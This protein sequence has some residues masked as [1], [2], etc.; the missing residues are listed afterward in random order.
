MSFTYLKKALFVSAFFY[1]GCISVHSATCVIELTKDG[2]RLS[3]GVVKQ[4]IDG[5]T[6]HL[7]DGRK[8]RLLNIDTPEIN[9]DNPSLSEPL[10]I[11]ARQ[12]LNS[13]IKAGQK[14]W[15]ESDHRTH[16]RFKRQLAHVYDGQKRHLGAALIKK[17]LAQLLILPPNVAHSQ[18]MMSLEQQA[19]VNKQGIWQSAV[20][21]PL[22]ATKATKQSG[23]VIVQGQV[24]R[25][26]KTRRN[27]WLTL[28]K[29]VQV[30]IPKSALSY[31][32]E[33]MKQWRL[34]QTITVRGY[35]YFS[36]GALRIKARHPSAFISNL[37]SSYLN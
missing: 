7:T 34:G 5:D 13:L 3:Q 23:F 36:H 1:I 20:Y 15:L 24:T 21:R 8:V 28:D 6:I 29:S 30:G 17:G 2:S 16:D 25:L 32:P 37:S 10:A 33:A 27:W 4:V 35:V 11:E 22:P 26:K 19:R 12:Y 18:C 9:H 31:F 14:I